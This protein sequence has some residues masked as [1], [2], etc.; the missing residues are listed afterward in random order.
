M[1]RNSKSREKYFKKLN[2]K[3][4]N[5]NNPLIIIN[6]FNIIRENP[7]LNLKEGITKNPNL[8]SNYDTNNILIQRDKHIIR[9]IEEKKYD[10]H[11]LIKL[12]ESNPNFNKN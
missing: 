11:N 7:N 10:S 9:E 2:K 1:I 3:V 4:F 5:Q 8:I 6:N 12:R